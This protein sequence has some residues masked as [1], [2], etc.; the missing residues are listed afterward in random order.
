MYVRISACQ[1]SLLLMHTAYLS[2]SPA[3]CT[4]SF[5]EPIRFVVCA[6]LK[7][8]VMPDT[9]P[10]FFLNNTLLILFSLSNAKAKQQRMEAQQ[11]GVLGTWRLASTSLAQ[12]WKLGLWPRQH[13]EIDPWK[14]SDVPKLLAKSCENAAGKVSDSA[15]F[16]VD[17]REKPESRILDPW[18]LRNAQHVRKPATTL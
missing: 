6:S 17:S 13:Q 11:L 9:S 8:H 1:V 2:L 3:Q 5:V 18:N 7:T 12:E 4:N 16:L 15:K 10:Q 14:Q